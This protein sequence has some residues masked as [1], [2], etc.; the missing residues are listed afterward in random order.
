MT[1]PTPIADDLAQ[2]TLDSESWRLPPKPSTS[3]TIEPPPTHPHAN[4]LELV[5]NSIPGTARE[6]NEVI[7]DLKA[8]IAQAV[9]PRRWLSGWRT[10]GN[11]YPLPE[12]AK[13][14]MFVIPA[15]ITAKTTV[16]IGS[17]SHTLPVGP[18][19][20]TIPT[21]RAPQISWPDGSSEIQY[22]CGSDPD[23]VQMLREVAI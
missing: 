17:V 13:W 21:L 22:A 12:Y 2:A 7:E 23:D 3:V 19:T 1:L 14:A 5:D 16:R 6:T 18:S 9:R 15:S 11:D 20:V 10:A 4:E 8:F